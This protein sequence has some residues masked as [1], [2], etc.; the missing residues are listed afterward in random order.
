MASGNKIRTSISMVNVEPWNKSRN[1]ANSMNRTAVLVSSVTT[2]FPPL[3]TSSNNVSTSNSSKSSEQH[4]STQMISIQ[5]ISLLLFIF[6]TWVF[7]HLADIFESGTVSTVVTPVW[8]VLISSIEHQIL[9]LVY[10]YVVGTGELQKWIKPGLLVLRG[11]P[12]SIWMFKTL[13]SDFMK[14]FCLESHQVT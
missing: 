1:K 12:R 5:S 11:Y 3:Q 4:I 6:Q 14:Y 9:I 7:V 8:M 2:S 13:L 10:C